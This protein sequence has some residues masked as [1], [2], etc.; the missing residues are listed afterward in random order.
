MRRPDGRYITGQPP[1]T[2]AALATCSPRSGKGTVKR[3]TRQ[4]AN[5]LPCRRSQTEIPRGR[6]TM[7]EGKLLHPLDQ[8][9]VFRAAKLNVVPYDRRLHHSKYIAPRL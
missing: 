3:V 9:L 7:Q 4:S 5:R 6:Y 2:S 8:L 1:Q